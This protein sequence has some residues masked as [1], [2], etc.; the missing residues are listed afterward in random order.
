M[1]AF[2]PG[3]SGFWSNCSTNPATTIA[4]KIKILE[5]FKDISKLKRDIGP[6]RL[7]S[8]SQRELHQDL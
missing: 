8:T 7:R 3:F 2:E 4:N 6:I 1:V 5:V